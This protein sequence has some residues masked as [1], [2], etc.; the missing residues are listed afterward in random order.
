M[1]LK[2]YVSIC[3]S[4]TV[5]S[6]KASSGY[7]VDV[8]SEKQLPSG[9]DTSVDAAPE[10]STLSLR[11]QNR[12]QAQMAFSKTVYSF[13]VTEDTVAGQSSAER[14]PRVNDLLMHNVCWQE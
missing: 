9:A 5:L 7:T 6:S 1:P 11:S 4:Q 2:L 3:S 10:R 8:S 13:E 14:R 12:W